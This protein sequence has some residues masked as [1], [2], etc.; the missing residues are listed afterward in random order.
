MLMPL[1]VA[2]ALLPAKSKASRD[3]DWPAPFAVMVTSSGQTATFDP[4]SAQVKCTFT[5]PTYQPPSP[6]WP[7]TT[8]PEI[9]G[10]VLSSLTVTESV[11]R[12]PAT[13]NASPL[14]I[15][16]A[17]SSATVTSGVVLV[18]STPEPPSLSF[19]SKCTVTSDLFH[20]SAF[21][22]GASVWVTI[23]AMLSYF[24][25]TPFCVSLL[26]ALSTA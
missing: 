4:S 16:P 15:K 8:A 24:S 11:P 6:S 12:L 9:V 2:V 5:G 19:A 14:T 1:T 13:S 22:E 7:L 17:V 26:P 21:G 20:W 3:T 10:A 25:D 18:G 23:G